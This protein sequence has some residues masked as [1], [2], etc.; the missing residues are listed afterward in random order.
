ME[1]LTRYSHRK[2][3]FYFSFQGRAIWILR[4]SDSDAHALYRKEKEHI[5][6]EL[7]VE[8]IDRCGWHLSN[9]HIGELVPVVSQDGW[10]YPEADILL[11]DGAGRP[12]TLIKVAPRE[13]F[14]AET[15][16]SLQELFLLAHALRLDASESPK[17]LVY[18]TR[19]HEGIATKERVIA[20]DYGRFQ[21]YAS[22]DSAARPSS[23]TLPH[24]RSEI[25]SK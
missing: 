20:I 4:D 8:L 10:S 19:W 21:S 23:D 3:P 14:D 5:I 24:G 12:C 6:A 25:Q 15:V 16:A 13:N 7:C 18:C 11:T 2:D 17:T 22:W 9:I 1:T